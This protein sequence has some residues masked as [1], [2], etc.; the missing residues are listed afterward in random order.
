MKYYI[1]IVVVLVSLTI[2]SCSDWRS[3]VLSQNAIAAVG[4]KI[5]YLEDIGDVFFDNMSYDD[6]VKLLDSYIDVWV[7][8]QLKIAEAEN[9]FS[10]TQ[11]DIDQKV[12][13]YRNSL[14]TYRI[15]Q[16]YIDNSIDTAFTASEISEFY[17]K[18]Q[19]DF[20]LDRPL[21]RGL[22]VKFPSNFRQ[23]P[24]LKELISSS[25][26]DAQQDFMDLCAKNNFEYKNISQWTYFN[27]T[28]YFLPTRR[29]YDYGYLMKEKKIHE[30]TDGDNIYYVY[31]SSV[32]E[33]G[34]FIPQEMVSSIIR[35]II[36]NARKETIIR[37]YEDSLISRGLREGKVEIYLNKQED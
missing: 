5:L 15:D 18:K 19:S 29:D 12:E 33:V 20:I 13:D 11:K 28:L 21:V 27:E 9:L 23:A 34:D 8:K 25:N 31:I 24:K 7:K 32:L 3:R 16:Y 26:A 1:L 6:S 14:L 2:G 37:S 36:S 17:N 35:R 22:M 4:D 30:F 10:S